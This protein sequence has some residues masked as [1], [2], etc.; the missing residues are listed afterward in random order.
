MHVGH[1]LYNCLSEYMPIELRSKH[2]SWAHD[3]SCSC[4][5][6]SGARVPFVYGYLTLRPGEACRLPFVMGGVSSDTAHLNIYILHP[7]LH[8]F[9]AELHEVAEVGS[10][11]HVSQNGK[12]L[13]Q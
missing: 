2:G 11:A 8:H 12:I 5:C 4:T 9:R 13:P 3:M 10:L 7:F 6:P 1:I